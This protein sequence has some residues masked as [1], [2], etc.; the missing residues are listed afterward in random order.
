MGQTTIVISELTGA[1]GTSY[2]GVKCVLVPGDVV[3]VGAWNAQS[4]A[5]PGL[6]RLSSFLKLFN[7]RAGILRRRWGAEQ[8]AVHGLR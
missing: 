1:Y 8:R 7:W 2:N 3:S 4:G 5:G 6:C